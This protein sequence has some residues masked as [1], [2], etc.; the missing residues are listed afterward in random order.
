[1]EDFCHEITPK[2]P[3]CRAIRGRGN[4]ILIIEY[5]SSSGR[6]RGPISKNCASL[7]QGLV[8][9]SSVRNVNCGLRVDMEG[10]YGAI[11]GYKRSD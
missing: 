6:G 1:M 3:P 8:S 11:F 9:K 2:A 5:N 7:D 10:E 4:G